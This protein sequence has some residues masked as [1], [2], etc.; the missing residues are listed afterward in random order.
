M[1]FACERCNA[2]TDNNNMEDWA[3]VNY[4][5]GKFPVNTD[6]DIILCPKCA[7]KLLKFLSGE[8]EK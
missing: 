8:S 1:K 3:R 2:V 7:D 5:R 4:K 6:V